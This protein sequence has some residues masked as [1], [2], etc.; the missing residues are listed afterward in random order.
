LQRRSLL[1]DEYRFNVY[2]DAQV[3]ELFDLRADPSEQNNVAPSRAAALASMQDQM[4]LRP[5]RRLSPLFEQARNGD[6]AGLLA[7]LPRIR[8]ESMLRF[9][10][11]VIAEHPCPGV[12]VAFERLTRRAGL[13]AEMIE[14]VSKRVSELPP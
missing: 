7:A 10:L 4:A 2:S 6:S 12:K 1:T 5:Y 13:S 8:S 9:A 14:T 3:R 11:E